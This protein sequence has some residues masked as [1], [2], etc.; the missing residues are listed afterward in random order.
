MS[1]FSLMSSHVKD[2]LNVFFSFGNPLKARY[3][4]VL[5]NMSLLL[6][7]VQN[8]KSYRISSLSKVINA[9]VKEFP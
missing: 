9:S 8:A 5:E 7:F 4:F 3:L 6:D 2:A 1:F